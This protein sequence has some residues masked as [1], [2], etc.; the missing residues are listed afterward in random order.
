LRQTSKIGQLCQAATRRNDRLRLLSHEVVVPLDPISR[1]LLAYVVMEA[2]T[3]WLEYSKA[4][5]FCSAMKSK[6][7]HGGRVVHRRQ[8]GSRDA[9]LKFAISIARP[10]V[11]QTKNFTHRHHPEWRDP[12]VIRKLLDALGA[13]NL[14]AWQLGMGVQSRVTRD[15][16]TMR[17]FFAHKNRDSA[18]RARELRRHYGVTQDVSPW[19]LLAVVPPQSGQPLVREWLDDLGAMISLT[20]A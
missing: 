7:A 9:A 11:K 13:S 20:V 1:R 14:A 10:D 15:L 16:P 8:L 18:E 17:N 2:G 6:S 12:G 3:M 19:E 4:Y 5:Y